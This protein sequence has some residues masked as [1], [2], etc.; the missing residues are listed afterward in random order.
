MPKEIP[1]LQTDEQALAYGATLT[2]DDLAMLKERCLAYDAEL[3]ND[4][5]SMSVGRLQY[6][7]SQAHFIELAMSAHAGSAALPAGGIE[8]G[9]Q[10]E[11]GG[12]A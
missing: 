10:T 8:L 9:E 5:A 7:R 6:L 11:D 3:R 12:P 4:M 1:I 2:R